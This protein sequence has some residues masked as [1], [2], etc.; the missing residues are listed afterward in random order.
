MGTAAI[1]GSHLYCLESRFDHCALSLSLFPLLSPT[2]KSDL[3]GAGGTTCGEAEKRESR[4]DKESERER[5]MNHHHW[6]KRYCFVAKF[7]VTVL[8]F[9]VVLSDIVLCVRTNLFP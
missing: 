4:K 2:T 6:N 5:E 1:A 7:T 8:L 9:E 3:Y